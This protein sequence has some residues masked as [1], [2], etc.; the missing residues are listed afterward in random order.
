MNDIDEDFTENHEVPSIEVNSTTRSS[1]HTLVNCLIMLLAYFWT[2]FRISDVAMEFLLS[3]LKNF[4]DIV[5]LSNNWFAGLAFAFPGT[6]YYF[7][8]EIGFV[9]D[10]FIKYVVCP[11]CC[12]L[13][14]FENSYRTVGSTKV[15]KTC[16]F[17]RYPNHRQRR[18]RVPCGATLLKEVA[19]KDGVK[20]HYPHKVYIAIKA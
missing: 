3:F 1:S 2:Y 11:N 14:T 4:F 10:K 8:K 17:V 20:R 18:M 12:A 15:S 6:L 16:S 19:L 5:A 9:K 7:R 13:Y